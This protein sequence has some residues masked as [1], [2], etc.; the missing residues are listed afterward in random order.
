MSARRVKGQHVRVSFSFEAPALDG[1][2]EA[3][4]MDAF[5]VDA[6]SA[7]SRG[8]LQTAPILDRSP[9]DFAVALEATVKS[10]GGKGETWD[11]MLSR[12]ME[13]EFRK[14][15]FPMA[16]PYDAA[17]AAAINGI[18]ARA[19]KNEV[20]VRWMPPADAVRVGK[21]A[22]GLSTGGTV[23]VSTHEWGGKQW[24]C[25]LV[26]L[27]NGGHALFV[28]HPNAMEVSTNLAMLRALGREMVRAGAR[29]EVTEPP[30]QHALRLVVME[31][32][33]TGYSVDTI[34]AL[35][36]SALQQEIEE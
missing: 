16:D 10:S 22:F 20:D 2:V 30:E 18:G 25:A 1:S 33:R 31:L 9:Q 17:L 4:D 27:D 19:P 24:R 21:D 11:R 12:A 35:V 29:G 3:F 15:V 36:T 32:R 5:D 6:S 8:A 26:K 14:A 7:E 23:P 28:C 34:K 13:A